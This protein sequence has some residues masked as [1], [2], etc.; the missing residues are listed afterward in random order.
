[1]CMYVCVCVCVCVDGCGLG[2]RVSEFVYMY[3]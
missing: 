2:G 3:A 1:M